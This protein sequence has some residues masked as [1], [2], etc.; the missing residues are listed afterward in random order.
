MKLIDW[1][2]V[3][4]NKFIGAAF[5]IASFL[6]AGC[7]RTNSLETNGMSTC[8]YEYF[9][10]V[11]VKGARPDR[12]LKPAN[13]SLNEKITISDLDPKFASF[14]LCLFTKKITGNPPIFNGKSIDNLK[15]THIFEL[16]EH[17]VIV[18]FTS[19]D[20][21]YSAQFDWENNVISHVSL[22]IQD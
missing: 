3:M 1:L 12:Y 16:N 8:A 6:S 5:F 2:W 10:I 4:L 20:E 7:L 19:G 11:N 13:E 18:G 22:N 21:I 15:I 14:A 9:E 17:S